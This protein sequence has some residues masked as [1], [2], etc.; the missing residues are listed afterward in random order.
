ML[1]SEGDQSTAALQLQ[2]DVH[3]DLQWQPLKPTI[4]SF[5]LTIAECVFRWVTFST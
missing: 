1:R 2:T 3:K 4:Y 5:S